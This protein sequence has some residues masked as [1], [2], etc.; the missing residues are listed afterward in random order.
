MSN[1]YIYH[2]M[3]LGD[4]IHCNGMVRYFLRESEYDKVYVFT[5]TSHKKSVDWM[6]R[7]DDRIETI[8][9]SENMEENAHKITRMIR[10]IIDRDDE[11]LE[12]LQQLTRQRSAILLAN[13]SY[14]PS[15]DFLI[16][17]QEFYKDKG[18][19][20]GGMPCD[21]IFYEQIN[22]PY[23]ERFD[24]CYW[25][26][27][28]EEE[29]RVYKKLAPEDGNYIFV[30]DDPTRLEVP[31]GFVIGDN[32]VGDKS[33]IIRNDLSES[34]FHFGKL[35]ENA[36]EI[37]CMESSIRCMIEYFKPNL[38]KNKVKLYMHK[39]RG[40]PYYNKEL[41]V[42]NGTHLPWINIP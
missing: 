4:M 17:G 35:L 37:H 5:K 7:D 23:S 31:G 30:H 3:G 42:W 15:D 19:D 1:L 39:F 41:G 2:N 29:E 33:T 11:N 8:G 36:K 27:D 20:I 40:G 13:N 10:T 28:M 16:V 9:V 34:I 6:Y 38:I 25:E 32:E 18:N 22:V 21:M 26:R 24:S 14:E 12:L